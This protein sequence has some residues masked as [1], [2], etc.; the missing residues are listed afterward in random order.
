M[1][2]IRKYHLGF[3]VLVI[4]VLWLI[5]AFLVGRLADRR[6]RGFAGYF[7]VSLI[8]GWPIPLIGAWYFGRATKAEKD[9][10]ADL[11]YGVNRQLRDGDVVLAGFDAD[12][13]SYGGLLVGGREYEIA[14]RGATG[15]H[16]YLVERGADVQACEYVPARVFFR[17]GRLVSGC[18]PVT[19]R[20]VPLRWGKWS[21]T[22]EAGWQ[23]RATLVTREKLLGLK[24]GLEVRLD[25]LHSPGASQDVLM[26]LAFA[27]W[28]VV[29]RQSAPVIG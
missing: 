24:H 1:R 14:R 25:S 29:R 12:V 4:V 18:A 17:G 2:R 23:V 11:V 27:C 16:F 21:F 26:L 7:V 13:G 10:T 19:L 3:V 22:S 8:I 28:I 20:G 6:G 9:M 5:P 15:W